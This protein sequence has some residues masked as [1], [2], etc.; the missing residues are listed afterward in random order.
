MSYRFFFS[1]GK[2]KL[3]TTKSKSTL[4]EK[5]YKSLKKSN[6][7]PTLFQMPQSYIVQQHENDSFKIKNGAANAAPLLKKLKSVMGNQF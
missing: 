1:A 4:Y 7:Q 2:I 6:R 5:N 3:N